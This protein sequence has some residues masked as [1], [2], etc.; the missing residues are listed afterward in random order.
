MEMQA[1]PVSTLNELLDKIK[2]NESKEPTLPG[3]EFYSSWDE[4]NLFPAENER[5]FDK[6]KI[7]L[8]G[9]KEGDFF[10]PVPGKINSPFGWRDTRMHKGTD[11]D[12]VKGDPVHA[13]FDGVIRIAG[14]NGGYGNLVIIRHYNGLETVYGHLSKIKVKPGQVVLAGQVIGSGGSTGHSTGAHLHFEIRFK[15]NAVDPRNVINFNE[16]NLLCKEIIIKHKGQYCAAYP[17]EMIIYTINK[18]DTLAGIAKRYGT[19]VNRLKAINGMTK[20]S[21]VRA[22]QK[23][24]IS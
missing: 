12:L 15:G 7:K 10:F 21:P 5:K 19:T 16:K 3:E 11:I 9:E 13:A 1:V 18:G 23:I 8:V 22:G 4:K 24:R 2:Q 14:K 6:E 20:P 17:S